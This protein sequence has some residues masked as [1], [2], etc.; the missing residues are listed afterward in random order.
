MARRSRPCEPT[1][2][3]RARESS[4]P[5]SSTAG[6]SSRNY[7]MVEKMPGA[8]DFITDTAPW[9]LDKMALDESTK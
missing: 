1:C 6:C 3:R 2:S 5:T 7:T 4:A 9:I 8:L